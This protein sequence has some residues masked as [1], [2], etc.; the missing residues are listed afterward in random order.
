MS[1][2]PHSRPGFKSDEPMSTHSSI[3]RGSGRPSS[4]KQLLF[5]LA[6]LALVTGVFHIYIIREARSI[7]TMA[8][9]PLMFIPGF[10]AIACSNFFGNNLRDLAL[11]PPKKV[12]M[13]Y[14]YCIPAV[15]VTLMLLILVWADVGQLRWPESGIMKVLL[16]RP[17]LSVLVTGVLVFGEELGWRGFLHTHL[18]RARIPE[19]MLV[20]GLIWSIW[21]WPLILFAGYSSSSLPWLSVLLFTVCMMSFSVILGWLREYSKSVFPCA[22]AHAVHKTWVQIIC[23]EF[24][25]AGKMDPFFGGESGFILAIIYLLIALYLYRNHIAASNY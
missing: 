5:F 11:V 15:C 7:S 24:Y 17:T 18:M 4:N 10:I 3:K 6:G 1:W 8:M 9:I 20:T 22:L 13:L 12:S 19:P 14:A 2:R 21:H 25:I 16:L 23:P